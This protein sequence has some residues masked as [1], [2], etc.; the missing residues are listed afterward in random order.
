M[1]KTRNQKSPEATEPSS[2][3]ERYVGEIIAT[4]QKL[5]KDETSVGD[6][7]IINAA[8]KEMRYAFRVFASYRQVRK[9]SIFGSART[10]PGTP[11]YEQAKRFAQRIA[12]RGFMI[13][14]G[15]GGG[16]MDA[17][18]RGAGRE[19]S[20]GINIRLP[21]EQE[22]NEVI[23]GDPKLMNFRYFFARKLFFVKEA[24]AATMF[25][26]GFGTHDEAFE[27]LTLIQT[28]RVTSCLWSFSTRPA[29][30]IGR[31][32]GVTSSTTCWAAG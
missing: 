9:V 27:S 17:C 6:L 30:S 8:L 12:D 21:F 20:F 1:S 15:A 31:P 7:K 26:G 19:R 16:I 11:A 10:Q 25:P 5:L 13:I 32:G 29:E 4:A 22:A 14:T 24:D 18:Q 28:G 2:T 23:R 3:E